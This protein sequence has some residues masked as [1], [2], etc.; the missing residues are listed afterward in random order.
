MN[1]M[2][3]ATGAKDQRPAQTKKGAMSLRCCCGSLLARLL[4]NG[5]ELKCRRCKRQIILPLESRAS[6]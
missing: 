1:P 3:S 4:P 6:M 2:R 5:V